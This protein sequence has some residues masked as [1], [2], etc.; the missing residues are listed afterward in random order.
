M[1]LGIKVGPQ[2]QS[3]EDLDNSK[4]PFC[5]VWFDI[6]KKH[7][8]NDLFAELDKRNLSVGL[9][10]WGRLDNHILANIAYPDKTVNKLSLQYMKDTIDIAA[11]HQYAY[12]NI[13]PSNYALIT[14][15]FDTQT[16]GIVSQPA[17]AKQCETLF[18]EH[19]TILHA[20]AKERNVLLTLE[21]V[22]SRDNNGWKGTTPRL[23]P[24]DVHLPDNNLIVKAAIEGF[25]IANDFGH[26]ACTV[27]SQ[28]R[29]EV[30]TNLVTMTT[31]LAPQTRL[32]HLGYII[33]PY[34]GTDYHGQIDSDMFVSQDA[35]PN[36][37]EM[38][39]LLRLFNDRQDVYVLAEPDGRHVENYHYLKQLFESNSLLSS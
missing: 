7:I 6:R 5:E 13:H 15:D 4:A 10:F 3:V 23:T 30:H 37:S 25:T 17:D 28:H 26:T 11:T 36:Q 21:T 35:I 9:H 19:L 24:L 20:Y 18:F 33:P 39:E 22:P 16:F 1:T 29:S 32:I 27:R 2:K 38:I 12:V 14:I 8:Y 34:N 31:I